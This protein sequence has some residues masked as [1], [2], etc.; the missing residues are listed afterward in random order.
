VTVIVRMLSLLT[1]LEHR[2]T[3]FLAQFVAPINVM[4]IHGVTLHPCTA[5]M[6][7]GQTF[8]IVARLVLCGVSATD[9]F[10]QFVEG[11]F[12]ALSSHVAKKT[13]C[14]PPPAIVGQPGYS[15]ISH[16]KVESRGGGTLVCGALVNDQSFTTVFVGGMMD[17]VTTRLVLLR[18]ARRMR[19]SAPCSWATD[20]QPLIHRNV[21]TMAATHAIVICFLILI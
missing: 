16:C 8:V 4:V 13:T 3:A 11:N 20:V 14:V 1:F 12:V 17:G 10:T 7:C 18:R 15:T 6:Y 19:V 5:L 9:T 21:R 2:T